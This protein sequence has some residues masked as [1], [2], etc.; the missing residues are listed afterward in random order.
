MTGNIRK[1][2]LINSTVR[3][4]PVAQIY[5]RIPYYS[6]EVEVVCMINAICDLIIG[7]IP[8]ATISA[9]KSDS[10]SSKV[11]VVE[12]VNQS[13]S[14]LSVVLSRDSDSVDPSASNI[15]VTTYTSDPETASSPF[16][17]AMENAETETSA[18]VKTRGQ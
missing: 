11:P 9:E 16:P 13:E 6:G 15:E 12:V 3:P 8:E 10:C 5:A 2:V 7:N 14:T 18:A 1:Y 4:C 17:D